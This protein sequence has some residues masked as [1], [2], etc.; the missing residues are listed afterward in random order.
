M[1]SSRQRLLT[2]A[3]M[4]CLFDILIFPAVLVIGLSLQLMVFGLKLL[5]P[6]G[7]FVGSA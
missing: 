6:M 2:G 7:A 5:A 3:D 1:L 4:V